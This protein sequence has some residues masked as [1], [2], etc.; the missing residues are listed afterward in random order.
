MRLRPLTVATLN[1]LAAMTLTGIAFAQAPQTVERVEVTGSNIKRVVDEGAL[2]VLVV[3]RAEIERSGATNLGEVLRAL[4]SLDASDDGGFS[5]VPTLSGY[6]GAAVSGFASTDTLVL[7]NGKRLAK[8]PV[9][10]DSVDV[11]GIPLSIVERVEVLRDGASAVYGS[12]AIAGVINI[13]TRS[14]YKGYGVSATYGISER[15]DGE[16][17]RGSFT[18]GFGDLGKDRYNFVFSVEAD[19][20][21]RIRNVDREITKSADLRPYGLADDRLPTSPFPNVLLIDSNIYQ[22][23]NPCPAPLPAEGV[24][25]TSAQPGKVCAFDPNAITQIQPQTESV[26]GFAQLNVAL[27]AG[28]KWRTEYFLK[29]KKSGNFLNPQPISNFVSA[30]DPANPYGED[31]FWFFRSTDQ[32]LYR[33]KQIEVKAQRFVTDIT[34]SWRNWDWSVDAGLAKSDYTESGSGY[35]VNSKFVQAIRTGVINP[36]TGKLNPDDL[37]PLTAAPVRKADTQTTFV[38]AK[39][40]GELFE[41]PAGPAQAAFG[42]G[43]FKEEYTNTPDPLQAAGAL[44]GDPRLAF[45][46]ANRNN[47]SLFAE[48][49][50]P[51]LKNLELSGAVRYDNYSGFGATTNPKVSIRYQ[52]STAVLLRGSVGK[53]FRAPD[54]EDLYASDVTGFPQGT[55]YAGC[56]LLGVSREDCAPKQIFTVTKSNANLKPEESDNVTLGIVLSPTKTTS[57]SIDWISIKKKNAVEALALQTILDNPTLEIAGYGRASNLI[58]RLPNGQISPDTTNP[59]AITPTANLAAIDAQLLDIAAG[60]SGKFGAVRL[61]VDNGTSL[62]LSRK[63]SPLP[64]QPLE[65]YRDLAGFAKWKNTFSVVGDVG[66]WSGTAAVKTIAS[67]LDVEE[68]SQLSANTRRVPSWTT[69]DMGVSYT[70]L[71][72]KGLKLDLGVRNVLD[73]LPPLSEARNTANK[74]DFAHSAVGRFYQVAVKYDFK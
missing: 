48:V 2:P 7:L 42:V 70:D 28:M 14:N 69:I 39:I 40:A 20:V 55:D 1:A 73:K 33:Q 19:K 45:V 52:P 35:F 10:G 57:L 31:V 62:L 71:Y 58:T 6:Q 59:V 25:V 5:L 23:I 54:L 43:F 36:F 29:S 8:Y 41:L 30:D 68:P 51:V 64:G 9:G 66:P 11:N 63:K 16:K 24:S 46:D 13:I 21:K 27:P 49:A 60:W 37:V 32:R 72:V 61:K 67:F 3:T 50:V 4:P 12:D 34:G 15:G 44:R 17:T 38:N 53:G 18:A 26:S 22:P 56:A 65:Q 74:I 47:K